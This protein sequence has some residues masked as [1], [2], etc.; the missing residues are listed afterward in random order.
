MIDA[1]GEP[2]SL[3]LL[4]GTSDI[5][6]AVAA[7]TP[8]GGGRPRSCSPPGPARAATTRRRAARALGLDGR[9]ARLRGRGHRQPP[10]AG[11][12]VAAGGDIDVALVAFGVLGDE[13][14]AWTDHDA[15]VRLAAGQLHR[16]GQR[17]RLPGRAGS[18]ARATA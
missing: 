15:A 1:L 10:G 12:A 17:R 14:E 8:A 16:A 2:Q 7:S 11:R 3:L 18:G 4:G 6:L 13:E 9:G 5:A